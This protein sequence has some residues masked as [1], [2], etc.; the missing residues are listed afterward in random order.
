MHFGYKNES[1]FS[2]DEYKIYIVGGFICK[3][4]A[5]CV[6]GIILIQVMHHCLYTI[7]CTR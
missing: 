1:Q 2:V 3:E 6:E 7:Q 4:C 5:I